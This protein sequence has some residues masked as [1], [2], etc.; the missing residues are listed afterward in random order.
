MSAAILGIAPLRESDSIETFSFSLAAPWRLG[1]PSCQRRVRALERL[2]DRG[3]PVCFDIVSSHGMEK[4]SVNC[5][6]FIASVWQMN[7]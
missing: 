6:S 2:A 3:V 5:G 1:G 4:E 7:C